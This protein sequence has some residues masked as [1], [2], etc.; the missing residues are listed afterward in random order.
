MDRETQD[1]KEDEAPDHVRDASDTTHDTAVDSHPSRPSLSRAL[2][3][4]PS[5]ASAVAG[6]VDFSELPG[7]PRLR[8]QILEYKAKL[9]LIVFLLV[10]ESSLLP[11]SLYYGLVLGT[12]L[13][14]GIVFAIITSFFGIVTGIEFSLRS[15]KL[16]FKGDAY[17]PVGGTRW[18][19][20]YTH[21]TL[22]L[23]YAVMTAI[24]IGASI[25]HDPLVRPLA[26]PVPLFFIQVGLQ[27]AWSGWMDRTGR[28]APFRISSVAKGG[29]VR[30]MVF[31]LIEDV[32]AVDGG[33]GREYRYALLARY[34]ASRRFRAMIEQQNWFWAVGA[35]IDGVGTMVVIWTVPETVA[36]GVGWG[37][38]LVFALIWTTISVSW[39]VRS[40][41]REKE[42]WREEHTIEKQ[43][44]SDTQQRPQ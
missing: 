23:G 41:R 24:L 44:E 10:L 20:D 25:P 34:D 40:L 28:L 13:R 12:T 26:M 21:W 18:S 33:G 17:R 9:S 27:L 35:L 2:S 31:T 42:L 22:T 29:R 30:P 14:R 39:A 36:Y 16:V 5:A 19:F 43:R 6:P 8:Y 3:I 7:L 37:S 4:V 32:V 11:I 15:Y 38:P 1:T